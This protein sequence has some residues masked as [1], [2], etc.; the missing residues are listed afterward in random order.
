MLEVGRDSVLCVH[1]CWGRDHAEWL[2]LRGS[3]QLPDGSIS[4][5]AVGCDGR[6][7]TLLECVD[8]DL[9]PGWSNP[10]QCWDGESGVHAGHCCFQVECDHHELMWACEERL[11]IGDVPMYETCETFPIEP[12]ARMATIGILVPSTDA[13]PDGD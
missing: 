11:P 8:G 6:L 3:W 9:A 7:L 4:H 1:T 12:V 13:A 5:E 10:C 2:V